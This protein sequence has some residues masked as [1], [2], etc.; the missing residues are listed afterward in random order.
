M[1]KSHYI[2]FNLKGTLLLVLHRI[3]SF[4]DQST[5]CC[6]HTFN[7]GPQTSEPDLHPGEVTF[8]IKIIITEQISSPFFLLG[9]CFYK[10]SNGQNNT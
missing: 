8:T 9:F 1:L 3:G 4:Q 10:G 6:L 5:S 7:L 2:H